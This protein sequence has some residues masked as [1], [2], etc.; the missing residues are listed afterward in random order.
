MAD[1]LICGRVLGI[2]GKRDDLLLSLLHFE[3]VEADRPTIDARRR[4]GLEPLETQTEAAQTAGQFL[5]RE[6]AVRAALLGKFSD[7][8]TPAEEGTRADD[9]G[10]GGILRTGGR[11]HTTHGTGFVH[12]DRYDLGLLERKVFGRLEYVLHVRAIF[13]AVGLRA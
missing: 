7:D 4:A 9:R 13:H 2:E 5:G 8:D 6:H 11:G 12:L 10:A 1:R 3:A